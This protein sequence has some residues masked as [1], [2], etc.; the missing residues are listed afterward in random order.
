MPCSNHDLSI[1]WERYNKT[2][3]ASNHCQFI[4]WVHHLLHHVLGVFSS[5]SS[6]TP[7]PLGHRIWYEIDCAY[8]S[9]TR[10]LLTTTWRDTQ[11]TTLNPSFTEPC[12]LQFEQWVSLLLLPW[13]SDHTVQ[14]LVNRKFSWLCGSET[15]L[16]Q[17]LEEWLK[18]GLRRERLVALDER[19]S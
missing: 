12:W 4:L 14:L 1:V 15:L 2:I 8:E 5:N 6:F 19:E 16:A 10:H 11:Q 18:Q 13:K 3:I 17:K 9:L 7:S